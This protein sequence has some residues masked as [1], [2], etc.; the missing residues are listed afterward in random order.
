MSDSISSATTEKTPFPESEETAI[1]VIAET[2][3]PVTGDTAINVTGENATPVREETSIT[4]TEE[5][6]DPVTKET[7]IPMTEET[8]I[9]MTEMGSDE[10]K[11]QQLVPDPEEVLDDCGSGMERFTGVIN[12]TLG[13][14]VFFLQLWA[15][16]ISTMNVDIDPTGL[17][18][19]IYLVM[20]A[21][22]AKFEKVRSI[23]IARCLTF[24]AMILGVT[25]IILHSWSVYLC[26]NLY[27]YC[28]T[29]STSPET[30]DTSTGASC[31]W[32]TQRLIIDSLMVACGGVIV[33]FNGVLL[34]FLSFKT[35]TK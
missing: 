14:L 10:P 32:F 4:V 25:L 6:A 12:F 3:A 13:V 18:V 29:I 9:P 23:D 2:S 20:L 31:R 16:L 15:L 11:D 27:D 30:L 22:L 33:I 34:Y 21:T 17:L 24:F 1:P 8:N 28:S 7:S 19:G 26:R 35:T 5:T